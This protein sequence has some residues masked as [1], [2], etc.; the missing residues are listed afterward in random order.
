ML[1]HDDAR[2]CRGWSADA[3]GAGHG[4]AP[5][6][7]AVQ[8]ARPV[9]AAEAAA[10]EQQQPLIELVDTHAHIQEPEF[11]D[12]RDA[13]IAARARG[14][15]RARSSC[16]AST[17][18]P[19]Q[20]AVALAERYDGVYATAGFHP[21]EASAAHDAESLAAIEALLDARRRS[22]RSARSASTSTAMHSPREAAD[23]SASRRSSTLAGAPS[24]AGRHPLPRRLGRAARRCSSRWARAWR[25][26]F[27]RH[28][29][30]ACCTTSRSDARRRAALHRARL[31]DL[32]P[33][34][35]HAPEGLAALREVAAGAAARGARHRDG[36]ALRRAA[37][38][39][40]A[41][42]TSPTSS[43]R[44]GRRR[45]QSRSP[46][47]ATRAAVRLRAA[48]KLLAGTSTDQSR[49]RVLRIEGRAS[50]ARQVRPAPRPSDR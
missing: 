34:L 21:H 4:A 48:G 24:P 11:A 15:R 26:R 28:G 8:E 9:V 41:S 6:G 13:V 17:S 47:A 25:P 10:G 44:A 18:R 37:G 45:A 7:A 22:S 38:P 43:R 3:A 50:S 39:Y 23:R 36:L 33:H 30:S 40:V 1:G 14:R 19:P 31:P 42:A 46:C 5:A 20:A 12:D 49:G 2:R 29:P 32:D 35:R 16:P 27:A